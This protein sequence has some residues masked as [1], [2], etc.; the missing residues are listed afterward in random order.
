LLLGLLNFF[1]IES[2]TAF[3]IIGLLVVTF[4]EIGLSIRV[5]MLR[6]GIRLVRRCRSKSGGGR[7][8]IIESGRDCSRGYS[9][10]YN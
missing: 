4:A 9:R 7:N 10:D 3:E 5:Y 6:H 8:T 1:F 2:I